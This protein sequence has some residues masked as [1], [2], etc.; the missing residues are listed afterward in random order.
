VEVNAEVGVDVGEYVEVNVSVPVDV[1]V[2][3]GEGAIWAAFTLSPR[4][5][6]I[7]P[8]GRSRMTNNIEICALRRFIPANNS[9]DNHNI[10]MRVSFLPGV[11]TELR[12]QAG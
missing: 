5:A 9:S 11:L 3:V 4:V 7:M 1:E 8:P 10:I 12:R 6:A 2:V